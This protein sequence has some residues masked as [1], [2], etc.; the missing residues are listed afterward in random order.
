MRDRKVI[1]GEVGWGIMGGMGKGE[2]KQMCNT[3][4]LYSIHW[5]IYSKA[6]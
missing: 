4:L 3:Q 2:G 6:R 1:R 5:N